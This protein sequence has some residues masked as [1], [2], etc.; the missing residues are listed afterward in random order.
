MEFE[1]YLDVKTEKKGGV[2][3]IML[4]FLILAIRW[5]WT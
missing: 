4:R 3:E 2:E 5:L 1:D